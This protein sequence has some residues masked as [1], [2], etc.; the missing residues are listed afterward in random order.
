M[1]SNLK[2]PISL[3][4]VPLSEEFPPI[5]LTAFTRP[6]LLKEVLSA[7]AQQSLL[8]QQILAFIDGPR[9]VYDGHCLSLLR[10][11]SETIP[12]KIVTRSRNLGCDENTVSAL[13]EVFSSYSALV[14]LEDDDVPNPC[15]YER[16]CRLLEAYRSHPQVFSLSKCLRKLP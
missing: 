10:E 9:T 15:F 1:S 2:L 11:F 12:V 14:Y 16:M 7:I 13:T 3:D 6:E 5:V 8:P 4:D